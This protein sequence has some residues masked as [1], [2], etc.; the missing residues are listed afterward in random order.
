M[1]S[2][3]SMNGNT[4]QEV[5]DKLKEQVKI[6][7]PHLQPDGNAVTHN[8]KTNETHLYEVNIRGDPQDSITG[9]CPYCNVE[10]R[11]SNHQHLDPNKPAMCPKCNRLV[12]C[13]TPLCSKGELKI[14]FKELPLETKINSA[15]SCS[16]AVTRIYNK[17][18]PDWEWEGCLHFE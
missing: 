1:G 7:F 4:N 2:T 12:N 8:T 5:I 17:P 3:V 6:I 15:T 16:I 18:D 10:I 9:T 14:E 13:P 11:L